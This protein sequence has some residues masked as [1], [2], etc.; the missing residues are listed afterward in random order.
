MNNVAGFECA[1]EV[2][3]K[4]LNAVRKNIESVDITQFYF[5]FHSLEDAAKMNKYYKEFMDVYLEV[6]KG[7]L[8]EGDLLH[9]S[10]FLRSLARY[11]L[12]HYPLKDAY[13][14]RIKQKIGE[15]TKAILNGQ[16]VVGKGFGNIVYNSVAL[17]ESDPELWQIIERRTKELNFGR[18]DL[19]DA[20]NLVKGLELK[21]GKVGILQE[22]KEKIVVQK[23][24]S[25]KKLE[26]LINGEDRDNC[27][28]YL[29]NEL[30]M[31]FKGVL[32]GYKEDKVNEKSKLVELMKSIKVL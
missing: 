16:K 3:E 30:E 18:I 1:E 25:V 10:V 15:N 22:V 2:T 7:K 23:V 26:E 31:Y 9:Y 14:L 6:P 17:E 21:F 29:K 12:N 27:L 5:A 4:Y 32:A 28:K 13:F 20:L 8:V 19:R 24:G 11:Y